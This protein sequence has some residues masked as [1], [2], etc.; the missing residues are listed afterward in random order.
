ML[1]H[2]VMSTYKF[3]VPLYSIKYMRVVR[4]DVFYM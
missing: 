3:K 1:K 4:I 2:I